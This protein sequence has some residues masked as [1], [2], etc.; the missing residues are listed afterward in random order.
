MIPNPNPAPRGGLELLRRFTKTMSLC[1]PM[2]RSGS[3]YFIEKKAPRVLMQVEIS[4]TA[5][6]REVMHFEKLL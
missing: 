4:L 2:R 6:V 3:A 5:V 1:Q